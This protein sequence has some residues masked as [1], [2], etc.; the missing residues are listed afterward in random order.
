MRS[1]KGQ[2]YITAAIIIIL[3]LSGI[4]STVTYAIIKPQPKTIQDLIDHTVGKVLDI[5]D[6][7][8][9]LFK[10]WDGLNK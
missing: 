3:A 7:P 6:I 1:K 4:A 5:F 9:E 10:R 8:H 2:F